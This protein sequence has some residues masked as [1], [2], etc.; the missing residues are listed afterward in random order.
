MLIANDNLARDTDVDVFARRESRVQSYARSFPRVWKR[1]RGTELWDTTGRRY[2]DFLAGAG[3]LNYGHNN[4]ILKDALIS[5][6]ERDGITHSLDLFT[7]A[8]ESFLEAMEEII[9][10]PRGLDYVVQF[11]GPTGTNAV[12]AAMKLARKITGRTNILSFTNGFHGVSM[13]SLAATANQ[14]FRK[15]A[16]VA[17]Q[18]VTVMPYDRYFGDEIDTV[19]LIDRM[20]SDP[21]SGID[22]PAAMLIELVQGEGG[23]NAARAVWLK[24]L[25]ALCRRKKIL[26]IVDDVQA[27]CG[28]T[29]QFFSFEAAGI[30]PD[31][32]TMS[33]SISGYGLP[34][35]L[36]LIDR[37][38]DAWKPGEH[39]GTFRGNNHAFVTATAA[40]EHYWSEPDF[41]AE[42][43]SK[44]EHLGE[45][46]QAIV[47]RFSPDIVEVKGRGMMRGILCADPAFAASVTAEAFEHGLII[48][49]AGAY[50]EVIKFL[51]PLTTPLDQL[52]EGIDILEAAILEM[53]QRARPQPARVSTANLVAV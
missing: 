44:S 29:S 43:T 37:A 10:Q 15:A 42:V 14:H 20:L 3:S 25:A 32:V 12:E 38:L 5:Y 52:N 16:G 28:R 41:E 47:D 31:I 9:L 7:A 18:G 4:P 51:M 22:E 45:R 49:R 35:A 50:D 40:L 48:E 13:G 23:L 46:L 17:L 11:T 8:K 39:N 33:K 30:K 53:S 36:V 26:L 19:S 1:A 27:G 21:S 24:R 6:I 34:F 2:L